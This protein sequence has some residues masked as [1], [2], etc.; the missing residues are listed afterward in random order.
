MI[1]KT[2]GVKTSVPIVK[3]PNSRQAVTRV[4]KTSPQT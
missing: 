4:T 1:L 3:V 2:S